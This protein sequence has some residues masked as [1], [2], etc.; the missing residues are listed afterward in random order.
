MTIYDV[1]R[2]LVRGSGSVLNDP[3]FQAEAMAAIDGAEGT[4]P[5]ADG[6]AAQA[7]SD[8]AALQAQIEA[9]QAQ[10]AAAKQEEA[11]Q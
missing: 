4:T 5:G 8:V 3:G 6:S 9:L 1:L 10:L 7:E 2:A 11:P